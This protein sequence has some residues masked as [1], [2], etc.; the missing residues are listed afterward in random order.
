MN[1]TRNK[2]V[3]YNYKAQV[4]GLEPGDSVGILMPHNKLY[5]ANYYIVIKKCL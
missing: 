5:T 3:L 2:N 1:N 4:F